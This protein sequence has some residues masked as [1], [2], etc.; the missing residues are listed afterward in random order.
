M[1]REERVTVQGPVKEQQPDGMSHRGEGGGGGGAPHRECPPP[2]VPLPGTPLMVCV[3]GSAGAVESAAAVA[4]AFV[5]CVDLRCGC[6]I[7]CVLSVRRGGGGGSMRAAPSTA[8]ADQATHTEGGKAGI[9]PCRVR[10]CIP[11]KCGRSF[12]VHRAIVIG[13]PKRQPPP[14]PGQNRSDARWMRRGVGSKTRKTTPPQQPAHPPVRQLLGS[15]NAEK[16]PEGAQTAAVFRTQR[17]DAAREGK[18][19]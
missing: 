13:T 14:P 1:R 11:R 16:T 6:C 18:N 19:G 12:G 10:R 2:R 8:P 17:P 15:A 3:A 4:H 9:R 5:G 7:K